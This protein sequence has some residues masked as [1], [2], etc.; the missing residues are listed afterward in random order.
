MALRVKPRHVALLD[1]LLNHGRAGAPV[2][3]VGE[4][5]TGWVPVLADLEAHG[6]AE[7]ITDPSRILAE[8]WRLTHAGGVFARFLTGRRDAA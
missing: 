1:E 4:W 3:I 5:P 6:L 8:R 2:E 7:K